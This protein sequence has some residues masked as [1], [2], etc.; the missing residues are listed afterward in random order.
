MIYPQSVVYALEA[1]AYL[2]SLP[3][4]ASAK[5][6]EVSSALNIPE[7]FLGKVLTT[8]VKKKFISSSKG[9]S[10]GFRMNVD[11][12]KVTLYRVLAALEGLSRLEDDCVM[13]LKECTAETP[14]AL[15]DQWQTFKE[16]AVHKAQHL[17][18]SELST[19]VLA[20]SFAQESA[21]LRDR[22]S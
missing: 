2:V 7:P 6:K 21:P 18:L 20:K 19:I 3:P 1:L 9:P 15:H 4:D 8:L 5:A 12:A 14:C 13:G 10:G 11:P 16:T 17:P 22:N